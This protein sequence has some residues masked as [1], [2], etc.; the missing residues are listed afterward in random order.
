[1]TLKHLAVPAAL[2]QLTARTVATWF[3]LYLLNLLAA[4]PLSALTSMHRVSPHSSRFTTATL[5]TVVLLATAWQW[6]RKTP[7]LLLIPL[8]YTLIMLA[9]SSGHNLSFL[10]AASALALLRQGKERM[11]STVTTL[12]PVLIAFLQLVQLDSLTPLGLLTLLSPSL[13]WLPWTRWPQLHQRM[14]LI[15]LGLSVL[16]GLLLP[17]HQP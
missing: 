5:V 13:A 6:R 10:L 17:F 1:M 9:T 14:L 2:R 8:L 3:G 15:S 4:V 11:Q 16:S 7:A 12:P